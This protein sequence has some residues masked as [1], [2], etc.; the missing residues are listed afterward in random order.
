MSH[1]S[2]RQLLK[3]FDGKPPTVAVDH[4]DLE[5]EDGE[6]LVLL[7]PSGCG[8][9]TTLR[10][11]AGLEQPVGGTISLGDQVVFDAD[12]RLNLTPDKRF[13]GMVFQSYALWPHM[14]V[15]KNIAYPLKSR[16]MTDELRGGRVEETAALVDCERL[17]DRLPAE[18]S[19]GQQQR[20]ALARGLVARP[21]LVLF[22]EP[23]SNLDARLRDQVRAELHDLHQ[24]N[25]FTA[26]FV[27]HDQSEAL[28]LGTR[29]AIMNA[30]R[31]VQIGTPREVFE[32]PAD[33][34]VAGFT[35]MS[36]RLSCEYVDGRWYALG[37]EL[38]GAEPRAAAGTSEFVLRLRPEKVRLV[39][40]ASGLRAG[41]AGI[42][43][44]VDDVEFGGLHL[45]VMLS[46]TA[47]D[48]RRR[49]LHARVSTY[50]R[51]RAPRTVER[52]DRMILAFDATDG[53]MFDTDGRM[54]STEQSAVLTALVG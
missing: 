17:L 51:S 36:N 16:K 9:T 32:E 34:Y 2:V 3:N 53:R 54:L 12:R 47:P 11:L 8:K 33:E 46:S 42:A 50:D 28:A 43:V 10:C 4:L 38:I 40:D 13:I 52:G 45:D 30:G 5:I 6:F 37:T 44:N 39:G 21:D 19:G 48:S 35:G 26:V 20:V 29:M 22:D 41:E 7:G 23:L 1:V 15:R 49:E 25:P 14:S 24:R 27:T 18:L 31:I